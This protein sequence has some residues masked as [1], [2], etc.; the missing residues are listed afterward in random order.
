[1][2]ISTKPLGWIFIV[3][4]PLVNF[5][6]Y[7]NPIFVHKIQSKIDNSRIVSTYKSKRSNPVI[8]RH[9]SLNTHIHTYTC[10]KFY[11]TLCFCFASNITLLLRSLL[12]CSTTVPHR[13]IR[14]TAS[15]ILIEIA[16]IAYPPL[17]CNMLHLNFLQ[18]WLNIVSWSRILLK[19]FCY[20]ISLKQLY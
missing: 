19:I 20:L 5:Y 16:V 14:R 15:L 11:L 4:G 17:L 18:G 9:F 8:F 7:S 2:N 3:Y 13:P 6:L 12:F 1:M 10:L